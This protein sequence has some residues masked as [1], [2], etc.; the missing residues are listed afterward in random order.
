M[1]VLLKTLQKAHEAEGDGRFFYLITILK[2]ISHKHES[3]K[4]RA[5]AES[6]MI[7]VQDM[8][9]R[10]KVSNKW[11]PVKQSVE[12]ISS[13]VREGYFWTTI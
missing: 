13:L 7:R 2:T 4:T 8:V 1:T 10:D 12:L 6:L 9:E 3:E 5:L 11:M